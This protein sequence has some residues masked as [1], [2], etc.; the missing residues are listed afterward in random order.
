MILLTN[1]DGFDAPG[2]QA[3]RAAAHHW[4]E[5]VVIA[6]RDPMSGVGHQ[7]TTDRSLHIQQRGEGLYVVDGTPVDCVRL[8]LLELAPNAAVV[9]SG[10][11]DGGNLGV[12]VHMSGTAAGAREAALL[13]RPAVAWS[14]YVRRPAG[15]DWSAAAAMV[16]LVWERLAALTLSQRMFWN[17]NFPHRPEPLPAPT[18]CRPDNNPLKFHYAEL[19]SGE[20]MFNGSYADR[21][22]TPGRDVSVCFGGGI[23]VSK[24]S[25]EIA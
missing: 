17:V 25:A 11:N 21:P 12:D 5:A 24:L 22:Q 20:R 8:G 19:D 3:L 6:P 15:P 16:S 14:Q 4:G 1:D 9:W 10:V 7:A 2:L 13:G 18:F 23:S